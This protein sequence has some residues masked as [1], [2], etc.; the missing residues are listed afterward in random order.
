ML[1]RLDAQVAYR[2]TPRRKRIF[3]PQRATATSSMDATCPRI[4][5]PEPTGHEPDWSSAFSFIHEA[6]YYREFG[7]SVFP[8]IGKRPALRWKQFQD[9]RPSTWRLGR[10][11][12]YLRKS[13]R[14]PTGIAVVCGRVSGRLAIRD[15]DS[16]DPYWRWARQNPRIAAMC[17]TVITPRGFHVYFRLPDDRFVSWDDGEL[18]ASRGQYVLLPPSLHPSGKQ[19]RWLFGE[20]GRSDFP[21]LTVA[22]TGFIDQDHPVEGHRRSVKAR[23]SITA[24][25]FPADTRTTVRI[26]Q[27]IYSGSAPVLAAVDGA[28]TGLDGTVLGTLPSGPG[29]RHRSIFQLTRLLKA[30]PQFVNAEATALE[31]VVREWH[32]LALP[33]I[34]TKEWGETWTDFRNAWQD[35]RYPAGAGAVMELMEAAAAG[36]LP[37]SVEKF[38]DVPTRKLLAVCHALAG[39]DDQGEFFLACRTAMDVC[40]FGSHTTAARRLKDLVECN[41]PILEVVTNG[42]PSKTKRLATTYRLSRAV[43][44]ASFNLVPHVGPDRQAHAIAT[45]ESTAATPCCQKRRHR[46]LLP[47]F[48]TPALIA[49]RQS[50]QRGWSWNYSRRGNSKPASPLRSRVQ[51]NSTGKRSHRDADSPS[52]TFRSG[53]RLKQWLRTAA[54]PR[55]PPRLPNHFLAN[56]KE[57]VAAMMSPV[58]AN[59]CETWLTRTPVELRAGTPMPFRRE[60]AEIA[61]AGAREMQVAQ[62]TLTIFADRS[63]PAVYSAALVGAAD[64]PDEVASWALEMARRR[65]YRNDVTERVKAYRRQEAEKHAE[66]MRTDAAYRERHE[67]KRGMHMSLSVARKLPPWPLG[68]KGRLDRRFRECCTH[69]AV[70]STLMRVR[71]QVAAEVLLAAIIEDLPE[72]DTSSHRMIDDD[73][74]L[75]FDSESYPTAYWKSPF[76]AFLQTDADTALAALLQLVDFC[77]ERWAHV[78]GKRGA[79]TAAARSDGDAG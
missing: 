72:E 25:S 37:D 45:S 71:P 54:M 49:P 23:T 10:L 75:G 9:K 41:P 14:E 6:L 12:E 55:P 42:T 13:R 68:G 56:H 64:L 31:R 44:A 63:E 77:T 32:R 19:Y 2:W 36:K 47:A 60:L 21:L 15:F 40:G 26:T 30:L 1:D 51:S 61:L 27:V 79:A 28:V 29:Q 58:V 35:V 70:L 65:D 22:Q 46:L 73:F 17:P 50:R 69:T 38:T 78:P 33:A 59:V 34:R 7:W 53:K 52:T 62:L 66:R 3:S 76:F 5:D 57:R 48:C 18:R 39:P 4:L 8:V 16:R 20:P 67:Q 11:A 74:G 24:P 43:L